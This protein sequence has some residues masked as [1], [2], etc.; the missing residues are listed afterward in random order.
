M[1]LICFEWLSRIESQK[2]ACA[3]CISSYLLYSKG[4]S[5]IQPRVARASPCIYGFL[6]DLGELGSVRIAHDAPY[7]ICSKGL[8]RIEPRVLACAPRISCFLKDLGALRRLFPSKYRNSPCNPRFLKDLAVSHG[9]FLRANRVFPSKYRALPCIP[10]FLKDLAKA[11]ARCTGAK[12][13][14]VRRCFTV[15]SAPVETLF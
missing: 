14:V 4:L 7:L 2:L 12:I 8:S 13:A 9:V 6:K 1:Y 5:C 3:H 15:I 10:G 11:Q